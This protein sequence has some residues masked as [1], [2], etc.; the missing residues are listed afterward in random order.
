[1]TL[2]TL[3]IFARLCLAVF[4]LLCVA[5]SATSSLRNHPHSLS[6]FN[7]AAGG[8]EN[9]WKHMLGSSFDW[10]QD[11]FAIHNLPATVPREKLLTVIKAFYDPRHLGIQC[12]LWGSG[13][14]QT[15]QKD[16]DEQDMFSWPD[17]FYV[18]S[19]DRLAGSRMICS[20]SSGL[21]CNGFASRRVATYRRLSPTLFYVDIHQRVPI[22]SE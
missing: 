17:G 15:L 9:G 4:A 10:G 20:D 7:E 22:R 11:L 8:P 18:V 16:I 14:R 5:G 6:Y 21:T 19:I 12:K 1:M 2:R 3:D 13:S